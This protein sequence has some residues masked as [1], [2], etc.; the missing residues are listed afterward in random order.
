MAEL[1]RMEQ[2]I[3]EVNSNKLAFCKFLATN[4]T[5]RPTSHQC[6]V[7][8]PNA[9]AEK[10]FF[11]HSLHKGENMK[12]DTVHIIWQGGDASTDSTCTY[13]GASKDECRITRFKR[14]FPFLRDINIGDL[15]VLIQLA[16]GEYSAW[17]LSTEEEIEGFLD[18]FGMSPTETNR[19]IERRIGTEHL[20]DME[21]EVFLRTLKGVFPSAQIMSDQ[22]R[23]MYEKIFDHVENVIRKPDEKILRW[24]N[25]EYALF[26]KVEDSLYGNLVYHGFPSMESFVGMANSILNRRKSRAGKSLENHLAA[27]FD[28]NHL[29]YEPQVKSEGNKRPDFIFP[30]SAAYHD[31][32]YA[33]ERLVFLG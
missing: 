19:L 15:F 17:L 12:T 25:T 4:D 5:I 8:I 1:T 13:Y 32:S 29:N 23:F 2:A 10:M 3:D 21:M 16:E 24:I 33:A 6:G 11:G 7:Y 28:G 9:V 22:A 26:A 27:I 14:G 20:L 30:G 31:M 18:Y